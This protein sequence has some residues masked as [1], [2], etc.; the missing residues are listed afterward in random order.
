MRQAVVAMSI[1]RN[2]E[3]HISIYEHEVLS[4][5]NFCFTI[6]T[7]FFLINFNILHMEIVDPISHT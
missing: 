1:E 7:H 5:V 4:W 2:G 6:F 3:M